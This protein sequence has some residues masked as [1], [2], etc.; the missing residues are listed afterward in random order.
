MIFE[1]IQRLFF[2]YFGLLQK[3]SL[4]IKSFFEQ[5]FQGYLTC[6]FGNLK[7][8]NKIRQTHYDN[9][10]SKSPLAYNKKNRDPRAFRGSPSLTPSGI[11]ARDACWR[12]NQAHK[13]HSQLDT[14][15]FCRN[16][17]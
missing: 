9:G 15:R 4:L 12:K 2:E 13:E 11:P 17:A 1:V 10:K 16:R 8:I 7:R 6:V 5:N 14:L 3:F